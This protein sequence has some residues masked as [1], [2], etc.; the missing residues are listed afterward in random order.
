MRLPEKAYNIASRYVGGGFGLRS[1][2][3]IMLYMVLSIS[4]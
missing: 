4:A 1:E 2:Q 3:I